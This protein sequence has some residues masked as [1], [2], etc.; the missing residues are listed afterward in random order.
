MKIILSIVFIFFTVLSFSE[1]KL[2]KYTINVSGNVVIIEEHNYTETHSFKNYTVKGTFEDNLGN[3]GSSST[4]VIAEYKEGNVINL[5]WSSK[6]TYQNNKVIFAQGVR[7]KGI[8]E[9]GVGKAILFSGEKPL[10]VLDN[11]ECNYA[12]KFFENNVF[13]KWLCN[14][15]EENLNILQSLN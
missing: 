10:N 11:T 13:A 9:A 14:I 7:K 12:I 15:P 4:A 1:E 6:L 2:N 8:D 5:Q 3:Y